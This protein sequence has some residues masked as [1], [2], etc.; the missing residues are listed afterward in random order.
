MKTT[1]SQQ[2]F[3]EASRYIPGGVNSPVRAC[4]GVGCDPLFIASGQGSHITTVDGDTLIDYVL[5]WGPL[6]LGHAH[7]EVTKAVTAA[8]AKGTSYGAPCPDEVL[9]AREVVEAFPGMDMVRMVNSGPEAAMSALRLAR[10]VTGRNKV[11]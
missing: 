5:S 7:P 6:L 2:L 11:L 8:A 10:A 1:R 3:A 9:L 4:R